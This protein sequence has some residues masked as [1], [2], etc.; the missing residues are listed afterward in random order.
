MKQKDSEVTP[1]AQLIRNVNAIGSK[2]DDISRM[3]AME[4]ARR[5]DCVDARRDA[6]I[7]VRVAD[8]LNEAAKEIVEQIHDYWPQDM[9]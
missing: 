5:P 1:K 6:E 2:F 8:Q 7:A 4:F 3:R 9:S